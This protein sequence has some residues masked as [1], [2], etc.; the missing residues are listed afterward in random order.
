MQPNQ[1]SENGAIPPLPPPPLVTGE[2]KVKILLHQYSTIVDVYKHNLDLVLK[3]NIFIYAITGSILSF[4]MSKPNTGIMKFAL[5]F[6]A[7]L[8]V[9]YSWFFFYSA[10]HVKYFH[11]DIVEIIKALGLISCPNVLFLKK[12]LQVSA[13]LLLLVSIGLSLITIFR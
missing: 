1:Q 9:S 11:M 5:I 7:I 8:N 4:Y 6:P 10:D 2:D 13:W 3:A 12:T